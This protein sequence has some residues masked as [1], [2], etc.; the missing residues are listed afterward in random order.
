MRG[1]IRVVGGVLEESSCLRGGRGEKE[2]V[3]KVSQFADWRGTKGKDSK[4]GIQAR[5]REIKRSARDRKR[6]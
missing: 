2:N 4:M 5:E 1:G 6:E 3:S